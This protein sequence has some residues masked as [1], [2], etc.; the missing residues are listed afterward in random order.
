M[1]QLTTQT[2]QDIS[3]FI[4]LQ[5]NIADDCGDEVIV[6][7]DDGT[8]GVVIEELP[9]KPFVVIQFHDENGMIRTKTGKVIE[10]F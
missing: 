7:I 2:K 4:G 5:A 8:I 1:T 3:D 10:V 6:L 9:F